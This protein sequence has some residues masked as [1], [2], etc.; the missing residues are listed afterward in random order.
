MMNQPP[1]AQPAFST[2]PPSTTWEQVVFPDLPQHFVWVWYKPQTNPNSF[3]ML[4]PP[5]TWQSH[6]APAQFTARYLAYVAG[7]DLSWV[8]AWSVQGIAYDVQ[9]HAVMLDQ[10]VPQ[11]PDGADPHI[12]VS[13]YDPAYPAK[14]SEAQNAETQNAGETEPHAEFAERA[15]PQT[16][17]EQLELMA[18]DW[19][20]AEK[21]ASNLVILRKKLLDGMTRLGKLNRDLSPQERL[22]ADNQDKKDWQ[23]ARMMLRDG[24]SQMSYCVKGFDI[25]DTSTAGQRSWFEKVYNDYIEPRREFQGM[26][27]TQRQFET[28][29]KSLV[30]LQS[31]MNST[32]NKAVQSGE[33]RAQQVM[34]RIQRKMRDAQTKKNFLGALLDGS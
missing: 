10:P 4:I 7:I 26:E 6:P 22:H 33:R 34:Q 29:R 27:Q 12:Y 15:A 5:E 20:A 25:G 28:Y 3:V 11:P 13:L 23:H 17:R 1:P 21:I 30:T 24:L 16:A 14:Q 19:Q 18:A 32:Y 2:R 8:A 31:K 9:H